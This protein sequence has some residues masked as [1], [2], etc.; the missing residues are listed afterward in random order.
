M[1]CVAWITEIRGELSWKE[2][3]LISLPLSSKGSGMDGARGGYRSIQ[4]PE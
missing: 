4:I 2:F 3:Q 1:G